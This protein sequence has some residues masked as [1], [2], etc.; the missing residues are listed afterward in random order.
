[1][2][3]VKGLAIV[4][5]L[6]GSTS[7]AVAQNGLPTGNEPPVAGGAY[8]NPILDRESAAPRVRT[9]HHRSMYMH[10]NPKVFRPR[11]AY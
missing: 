4:A 7:L 10:A 9:H 5:L 8:G 3:I 6:V 1:M 11:G 2:T